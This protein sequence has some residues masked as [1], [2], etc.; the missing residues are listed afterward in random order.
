M[1]KV[2]MNFIVTKDPKILDMEKK[3]KEVNN[4]I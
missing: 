1:V 3:I 2:V 4:S